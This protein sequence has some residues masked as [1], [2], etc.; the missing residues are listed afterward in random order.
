MP[1]PASMRGQAIEYS[2]GAVP[3]FGNARPSNLDVK[4][5]LSILNLS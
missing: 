4:G 5:E 2:T 1:G 3:E